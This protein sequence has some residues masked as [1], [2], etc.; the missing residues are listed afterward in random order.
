MEQKAADLFLF[1]VFT[2]FRYNELKHVTAN[3]ISIKIK[4]GQ[5]FKVIN[6]IAD[7]E[8]LENSVPLTVV[9][10]EIFN[11]WEGKTNDGMLL[12]VL[13]EFKYNTNLHTFLERIPMMHRIEKRVRYRGN[14]RVEQEMPRYKSIT[15]HAGRHKYSHLLSSGGIDLGGVSQ[16][17]NH[18]STDTTNKNYKHLLEEQL[19]MKALEV[20]NK[21]I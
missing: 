4:G 16:L 15:S 12:P 8:G 1:Q 5:N 21:A 19:Q 6:N 3:S 17:M 18:A 13:S 7:K 9:V 20:L 2:G 14:D 10:Q 11:R